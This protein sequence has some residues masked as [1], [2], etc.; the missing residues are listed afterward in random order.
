MAALNAPFTLKKYDDDVVLNPTL[1]YLFEKE[2]G[3]QLP[4]FDSDEDSIRSYLDKAEKFANSHGWR[5]IR[6]AAIGLM[7]F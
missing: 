7:S 3:Y 4:D 5:L 1:S 2:L 6:E